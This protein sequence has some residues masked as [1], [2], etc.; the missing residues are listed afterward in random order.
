MFCFV[1]FCGRNFSYGALIGQSVSV[2]KLRMK[3][4]R[5]CEVM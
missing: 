3:R 1:K 4:R 5:C 2:Y